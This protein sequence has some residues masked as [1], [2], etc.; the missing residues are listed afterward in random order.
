MSTDHRQLVDAL[1]QSL[2]EREQLR[3]INQSLLASA[4][5]PI[6]IV[7]MSCRL[8]GGVNSPEDLWALVMSGQSA[9][10]AMP[11]DRG[12]DLE[13][14][15]HPSPGNPGT[16]Y[17][18]AG[19]FLDDVA[20][21]DAELFGISPREALAMDP[22]QRLLLEGAWEACE[23]AGIAPTSLRGSRTGVFAGAS[24]FGYG[25]A[26]DIY[27]TG[28]PHPAPE[29]EGYV[30]TGS[31][32]SVISGRIAYVLGLEGPA[33]SIDT[34]CSSSLVAIHLACRSLRAK[35]SD[36]ALAGGATV[37]CSPVVFVEFSRQRGLAA[38]GRC[39]AF[40]AAADGTG[41]SEG[42]GVVLLE[43][44]SDAFRHGHRVLA[45]VR[46]SA[47]NQD[48]ASNGLTAPNGPSQE[49]L[50]Q[51]GLA[52]ANLSADHIDAV[53]AHGT[54][55]TLGDPIEAH[56]LMATYGQGRDADRPLWLGSVKSNI[57]H[58]QAA[59]GIAGVIKMV[60][61][62]NHGQLPKTLHVDEPTPQVDWS[63]G[64]VAL[65]V[66]QRPWPDTGRPRRAG[67]S[68]FGISG[69]NAHLILE[70][71]PPDA[72]QTD[73]GEP[74]DARPNQDSSPI[75]CVI[76]AHDMSALRQQ[77]TRLEK[78]A[79]ARQDLV[80][81]GIAWSLASGRAHLRH[82]A[83]ILASSRQEL[84]AGLADLAYGRPSPLVVQ[85]R[86]SSAGK[87]AFLFTGQG[88][89][90]QGMG[91][92]L[93]DNYPGFR[94][95]FDNTCAELSKHLTV[96]I[97]SVFHPRPGTASPDDLL[98]HTVYTQT[99]VFALQVA[100]FALTTSLGLRPDY[101][102]GHSS[103]E[104]AAVHAA[105]MLS[106]ADACALIAARGALMQELPPGG[107]MIAVQASED[108]VR[109]ITQNGCGVSVAAVN[110]PQAVVLSGPDSAVR[111][112]VLPFT[113]AGRRT[114]ELRVSHP[115]HSQAVEPILERL[116]AVAAGLTFTEGHTP[117]IS[118][119]TGTVIEPQRLARPAYWAQQARSTVRFADSVRT[120]ADRGTRRFLELGPAGTLISLA[121][122]VLDPAAHRATMVAALRVGEQDL[123][124]LTRAIATLHVSGVTPC[125]AA[126]LGSLATHRQIE[127]PTYPFQHKRYWLTPDLGDQP[128]AVSARAATPSPAAERDPVAVPVLREQCAN[129][130]G[131][132]RR[133]I[134]QDHLLRQVG[135]TLG[136]GGHVGVEAD[137]EFVEL[138]F[139]SLMGTQLLT[140][141][142]EASGLHLPTSLL[143]DHP[144]P[145]KLAGGIE[146]LLVSAP[147]LEVR[148]EAR[149]PSLALRTLF[150]TAM[151]Q[152]RIQDGMTLLSTAS[153]IL[154]H[155]R[156][157]S[158]R[159]CVAHVVTLARGD[160]APVLLCIPSVSPLS[161]PLQYA[162][163]AAALSGIRTLSTV[164]VPG[165]GDHEPLPDDL[166]EVI[167][168]QTTALLEVAHQ[169]SYALVGYSSG[170][171]LA[172]DLAHRLATSQHAPLALIL[173]DTPIL[174]DL[175]DDVL[176]A[177][178]K[179]MF[180]RENDVGGVT[181]HRLI[182][183]RRYLEH[184]AS[185][186]PEELAIPTVFVHP[187]HNFFTHSETGLPLVH[188]PVSHVALTTPGDHFTILENHSS[189]TARTVN[190]WLAGNPY[191]TDFG[192]HGDLDRSTHELT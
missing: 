11:D 50:I 108:E 66:D 183:W 167:T 1:R 64:Q 97:R 181:G 159:P 175:T 143:F 112:A 69:T 176:T 105:G 132:E 2:K 150:Q 44:L 95:A 145:A 60:L 3:S 22:H 13:R 7:G 160:L 170:G 182:T 140:A 173:M 77:A 35:E 191:L 120:A 27:R 48:G 92:G 137:S 73:P 98:N 31:A 21:F 4:H 129:K 49:R 100:L 94:E 25:I 127:L 134:I 168:A 164:S 90:Y 121:R 179:E 8:P 74:P 30:L 68:S 20:G 163:L 70:Q 6:A 33:I 125:W 190:A 75:P 171:W 34:A 45:V 87:L 111:A 119:V 124:T 39:K 136:Y 154:R 123:R 135:A 58:T 157:K 166:T 62:I 186:Q 110:G 158:A 133:A 19:G 188:W 151:R 10:S 9:L 17:A 180:I 141:L 83:V 107:A 187:E 32:P 147:E 130:P 59:A 118:T 15:Y 26:A 84:L 43:R 177:M 71:A 128:D 54:G 117:V 102:I 162:K 79:A 122:E 184:Y 53:E 28:T 131:S 148:Q 41:W 85:G 63:L 174:S 103:G 81:H 14:L 126:V 24:P 178:T 51:A 156:G 109:H 37:I 67:V 12:W 76:S 113:E 16:S 5:E 115:F 114:R 52:D 72:T 56:A 96:D 38:D 165:Y 80:P 86:S 139:D 142:A 65:L 82:R 36:L 89:Q 23:H 146:A 172:H 116:T 91:H 61:A 99:G 189:S 192:A 149:P 18:R 153:R 101:L 106:L 46:G 78:L 57:G 42:V 55:T 185:W 155:T 138:G 93:L 104:I 29:T 88:S 161:S 152:H 169:G 40:A 47:I 144:T